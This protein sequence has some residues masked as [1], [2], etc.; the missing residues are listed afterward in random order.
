MSFDSPP[1]EI[2]ETPQQFSQRTKWNNL[3]AFLNENFHKPDLEALLC[4]LSACHAQYFPGDPVWLFIIGPS[5]SGKT[6]IVVNCTS[7][8]PHTWVE[9]SLSTKSLLSGA[10]D[11]AKS[12]LLELMGK[13]GILI[14]KD[15]TTI[16]SKRDDDQREIVSQFR[17]VFDGRFSIRTGQRHAIWTGKATVIAATTPAIERAWAIHRDLGERFLQVRWFGNESLKIA[18]AARAQR[19]RENI[20]AQEMRALA[21]D[22]FTT[23]TSIP[24]LS[25]DQGQKID[26][27]ATV[28]AR[29]RG[30]VVRDPKNRE[31]IDV[32]LPE[33]PTRI[34]KGLETLVCHHAAL[35]ARSLITPQD[36]HIAERV[37]FDS[38]PA[39]RAQILSKVPPDGVLINVGVLAT[40]LVTTESNLKYHLEELQALG[41]LEL[42]GTPQFV[43]IHPNFL[44]LWIDAA[45]KQESPPTPL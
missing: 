21:K 3:A 24:E 20:I 22:F 33:E 26:T 40:L 38:A 5:G 12:S 41:I 27:L 34:A 14:F 8:L 2:S 1:V 36:F 18:E 39:K 25:D 23:T 7:A 28:I 44:G 15:F 37:G 42:V 30:N 29:L 4:A 45:P 19:G 35:F 43:R 9:S 13:S 31:I 16:I 6:S 10:K 32:S 11:G 17:E